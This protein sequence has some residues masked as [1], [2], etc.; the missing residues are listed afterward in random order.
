MS[1]DSQTN[2][3]VL[4]GVR[5]RL[6][7][8][9]PDGYRLDAQHLQHDRDDLTGQIGWRYWRAP[10]YPTSPPA[11]PT[12]TVEVDTPDSLLHYQ[13]NSDVR[14]GWPRGAKVAAGGGGVLLL[15]V[16]IVLVLVL[17]GNL[18]IG[19]TDS[20][21]APAVHVDAEAGP[22]PPS[23]VGW[24]DSLTPEQA[25]ALRGSSAW[26]GLTDAE[27]ARVRVQMEGE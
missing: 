12:P 13:S 25:R 19:T 8:P 15:G 24:I 9:L 27:Q 26:A 18:H 1:T 4:D 17:T 3:A 21:P 2:P 11:P 23:D 16:I 14:V 6:Q 22:P 7:H 10:L 20:T 5:K